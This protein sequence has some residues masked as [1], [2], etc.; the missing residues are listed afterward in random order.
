MSRLT[1]EFEFILQAPQSY[2]SVNIY[3]DGLEDIQPVEIGKDQTI[4]ITIREIFG[5][6]TLEVFSHNDPKINP[7]MAMPLNPVLIMD[8]LAAW[9]VG[10]G[11]QF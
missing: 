1:D 7:D 8:Q 4:E 9:M 2:V 3:G 10:R 5:E 6:D 11:W